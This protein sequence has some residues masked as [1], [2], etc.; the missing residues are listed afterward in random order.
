MSGF[1][2]F[3]GFI[4]RY[5]YFYLGQIS[6]CEN[7]NIRGATMHKHIPNIMLSIKVQTIQ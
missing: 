6:L 4:T 1:T 5:L 7:V 2:F 3:T